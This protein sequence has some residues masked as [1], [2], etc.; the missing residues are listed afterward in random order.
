ML[1]L[2]GSEKKSVCGVQASKA[3]LRRFW[4]AMMVG[5]LLEELRKIWRCSGGLEFQTKRTALYSLKAY[6]RI[7]QLVKWIKQK[8][9]K[10]CQS[11]I[12]FIFLFLQSNDCSDWLE[13]IS[14]CFN[15][16]AKFVF[17][18]SQSVQILI[19][20][21][22]VSF[23]YTYPKNIIFMVTQKIKTTNSVF[24]SWKHNQVILFSY[25][26]I[27]NWVKVKWLSNW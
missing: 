1:R 10:H 3:S 4:A 12:L 27:Q 14:T 22:N 6:K 25:P 9:P 8:K 7:C 17:F 13:I 23:H 15:F 21:K 24:T 26:P 16:I 2:C 11:I 20:K 18:V 19:L 5:Y